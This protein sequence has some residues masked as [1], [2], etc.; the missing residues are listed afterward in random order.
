MKSQ[1]F[2]LRAVDEEALARLGRDL[3]VSPLLARVLWLRGVRDRQAYRDLVDGDPPLSAASCLPDME[4]AVAAIR[5]ALQDGQ[6]IR[7]YGDYDADGVTATAVMMR[8]LAP[9]ARPGQVDWE[10]PNRFDEGYGLHPEAVER[11]FADGVRLLITVDCGSSSP[12]AARLAALRGVGLVITD[13]HALAADLPV[14]AALVNPERMPTPDR[15][16]GAGVAL[17]VIRALAGEDPPAALWGIAAIGT[18]A[19]VVPLIGSNRAIVRRG[20]DALRSGSVPGIRAMCAAE[21][22][23]AAYLTAEDLGFF[24]GPRLNAAGRMGDA[25]PAVLALL[26]DSGLRAQPLVDQMRELNLARRETERQVR[27]AAWEQLGRR[28]PERLPDFVVVGGEGW[29]EGVVGIVA[30]R[31]REALGRPVAVISWADSEGKGSARSVE[32]FD[33]IGHLRRNQDLF[34]RL[35][36][37]AGAAGFSLSRPLATD[38]GNAL[39]A[40][41]LSAGIPAAVR[42]QHYWGTPVDAAVS[43][44]EMTAGDLD[45]IRRLEPFGRGFERPRF[46]VS[47]V[48]QSAQTVGAGGH[49]LRLA[50]AGAPLGAIAFGEGDLSPGLRPGSPVRVVAEIEWQRYRG[51][52][53]PGW[54]VSQVHGASPAVPWQPVTRRGSASAA[55][56]RQRLIYVVDSPREQIRWARTVSA[57][58]YHP[59][60]PP[61]ELRVLEAACQSG[62]VTRLVVSQW[63]A[64]PRLKGWADAVVWLAAPR[65]QLALAETAALLAPGGWQWLD[66]NLDSSGLRQK[67]ERLAPDRNRLGQAW[68]RWTAGRMGLQIGREI[69]AELQL[70]PGQTPVGKRSLTESFSYAMARHQQALEAESWQSPMMGWGAEE[71]ERGGWR[72]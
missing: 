25:R 12:D 61:G 7:I 47:G 13:H 36:G 72:G 10:I 65:H 70:V 43:A 32:G 54:R 66:P 17:Q 42:A 60:R 33:L 9:W 6:R 58:V 11:A 68:R 35:G 8:G 5:A 15:L 59:A 53:T 22:R 1:A 21:G 50:L 62:A 41:R 56:E 3:G 63:R 29:H 26:A 39:L 31:L 51:T 20:L 48:V 46:L 28:S 40:Q 49:H 24:V 27:Q 34:L 23:D 67:R 19:D 14:A 37:H 45:G 55:D 18:V 57:A 16:S 71:G 30:S 52:E 2:Y 69:F 44:R 4:R 38:Q 64:W